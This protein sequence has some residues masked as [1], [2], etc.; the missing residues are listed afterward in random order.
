MLIVGGFL[1]PSVGVSSDLPGDLPISQD[2]C[3][4][5]VAIVAEPFGHQ[6]VHGPAHLSD[7]N[8]GIIP[9]RKTGL[10]SGRVGLVPLEDMG[11]VPVR[12]DRLLQQAFS[13]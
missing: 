7:R 13:G 9:V 4:E 11:Q 2:H 10:V 12:E 5:H 1:H 6:L 8:V 3:A